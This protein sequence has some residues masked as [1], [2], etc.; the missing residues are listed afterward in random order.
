MILSESVLL[1]FDSKQLRGSVGSDQ[2][3]PS[4]Q[5]TATLARHDEQESRGALVLVPR[6]SLDALAA[7]GIGQQTQAADPLR[8]RWV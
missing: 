6:A 3:E 1:D 8:Q 2:G 5:A 7:S 4:K